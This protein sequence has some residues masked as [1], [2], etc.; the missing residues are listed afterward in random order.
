MSKYNPY[1]FLAVNITFAINFY[2]GGHA[3]HLK[4][5]K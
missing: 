1:S 5:G 4:E 2:H 3:R